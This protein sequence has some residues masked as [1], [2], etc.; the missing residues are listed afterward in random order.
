M[1]TRTMASDVKK[2]IDTDLDDSTVDAYIQGASYT[3]DDV[4]GSSN[5]SPE[6]LTEIERWL[7]AHLIASTRERQPVEAKA[8]PASV[9][10]Q[11]VTGSGLNSTFYGQTVKAMDTSGRLASLGGKRVTMHAIKSFD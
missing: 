9:K 11:G 3:I 2:I 1:A 5:L 4:L 7:T 6:L 10:Y 8:G